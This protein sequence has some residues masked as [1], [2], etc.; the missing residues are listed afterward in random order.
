MNTKKLNVAETLESI[1]MEKRLNKTNFSKLCEI[2]NSFYSEI[3]NNKKS[4][5]IETLEKICTNIKVPIEIFIFKAINEDNIKDE[6]RR[7]LVREI[8]PLMNEITDLLYSY[9]KS[10]SMVIKKTKTLKRSGDLM[11]N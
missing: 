6:T 11:K 9:N 3:I 4:V 8:K 2:S 1:R 5:N 10:D 7:K